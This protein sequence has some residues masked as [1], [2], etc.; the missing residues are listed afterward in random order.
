MSQ[1]GSFVT[2]YIHCDKCLQ[3]AKE[4]LLAREKTLCSTIIQS[5]C[6]QEIPIIAGKIGGGYIGEEIATFD[7]ELIPALAERICHPMRLAVLGEDEGKLYT[8]TPGQIYDPFER[9]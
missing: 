3:A 9:D 7:H 8:I 4:V 2:E 5:W 6:D 1:R